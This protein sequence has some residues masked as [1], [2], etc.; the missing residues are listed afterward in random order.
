MR[1]VLVISLL[2]LSV[3]IPARQSL[4][5]VGFGIQGD[6][7]NFKIGGDIARITGLSASPGNTTSLALQ[8]VYGLGVGGGIHFD[9]GLPF[10]SFRISGDYLTLSP[11]NTK[12]Q[13]F[14]RTYVGLPGATVAV[15][16]GRIT[17]LSG[18]V[19]LKLN[20]L[21]LPVIKPYVTGGAGM[22]NLKAEDLSISV[23]A[24]KV[25]GFQLIQTQT[26]ST[27]NLGAGLDLDFGGIAIFGE[28]KVNWVMLKEGTSVEV[29]IATAG[30]TF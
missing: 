13:A 6:V 8:E 7:T 16:G 19:N 22:A 18:N 5:G 4:A 9:I 3:A 15:D 17:M 29:P 12:F 28:V 11:D 30:I 25:S 10:L 23:G 20:I 21:P 2:L 26:V 24:L 1:R 14:V 27:F